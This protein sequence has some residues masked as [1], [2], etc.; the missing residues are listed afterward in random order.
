MGLERLGPYRIVKELG[1]GGMGTVYSAVEERTG[2][3]AAVKVLAP[4]LAV[5]EGFRER[6]E[7]EIDSLKTLEHPN[8]V[9]LFGYGQEGNYLYYAMELVEG[10]SLEDELANGRR[11]AW[12]EACRIG[13]DLCRALKLAH[14]HG[15]IHRDIKPAN[16]LLTKDG[17]IKLT[18]FGIARLFGNEGITADGGVLGTAE[19]MAPEQAD[20]RRATHRS[21]LY[22]LGGVLYA[23]LA[24]RAPFRSKSMLEMLQMQRF[25]LPEPVRRYAADTPAEMERII[26]QLLEKDPADRLPNALQVG[27]RLEAML[28]GLSLRED[29]STSDTADDVQA[30]DADDKGFVVSGGTVDVDSSMKP[31]Q[32]NITMEEGASVDLM[33]P[34]RVTSSDGWD[35]V[36]GGTTREPATPGEADPSETAAPRRFTTVEEERL[37]EAGSATD[38][39]LISGATMLLLVAIVGV[40]LTVWL[41]LQP[42]SPD[43]LYDRITTA[44]AAE[45][46]QELL[47][48]ERQVTQFLSSHADDARAEEVRGY[49]LRIEGLRLE[50]RAQLQARLLNKRYPDSPIGPE[51]L[52]AMRLAETEPEQAVEHLQALIDLFGN[53][54]EI[55][56][57]SIEA[58]VDAA[59]KQVP[60]LE[61][62]V[63]QRADQQV[64][65]LEER[66][67]IAEQL[68]ATDPDAARRICQAI[69]SLYHQKPWARLLVAKAEAALSQ[70]EDNVA[71]SQ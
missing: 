49:Q 67:A 29:E 24:G 8:I 50:R 1:R 12:R 60:R 55:K 23:L 52:A 44:A 35:S 9:K 66:L 40:G 64:V 48:V 26:A 42:H 63:R 46:E 54:S 17:Q 10:T 28:H 45:D 68:A 11:F 38:H 59:R 5:H 58:F 70:I 69:V 16:L 2:T 4:Q 3:A 15:I 33:G 30:I 43:T 51:Y 65:W 57:P 7:A 14:D 61:Q 27:R 71:T 13:I 22:S 31:N 53:P 34:T 20:G 19:Y 18:D 39:P 56:D 36:P 21:D 62:E 25:S 32:L 47:A 41:I 6:F 37:R